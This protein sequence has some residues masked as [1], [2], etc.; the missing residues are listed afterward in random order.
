ML[1]CPQGSFSSVGLVRWHCAGSH[2]HAKYV[3]EALYFCC[4]PPIPTGFRDLAAAVLAQADAGADVEVLAAALPASAAAMRTQATG[5]DLPLEPAGEQADVAP[6]PAD[7]APGRQPWEKVVPSKLPRD[8]EQLGIG[9]PAPAALP[10]L[11]DSLPSISEDALGA[12]STLLAAG[13]PIARGGSVS[14]A[15]LGWDR[16]GPPGSGDKGLP[17]LPSSWSS[18]ASEASSAT[19]VRAPSAEA[20][21]W[22]G[23]A[24]ERSASAS[25]ASLIKPAPEPLDGAAASAGGSVARGAGKPPVPR[26]SSFASGASGDG[27][28][29]GG[30]LPGP[31]LS[32]SGSNATGSAASAAG[33]PSGSL[34]GGSN[35]G[36]GASALPRAI[37]AVLATINPHR[38]AD[39]EAAGKEDRVADPGCSSADR[40]PDRAP[41]TNLDGTTDSREPADAGMGGTVSGDDDCGAAAV[42]RAGLGPS[43]PSEALGR[44]ELPLTELEAR[45]ELA[46]RL[47]G[48]TSPQ[49]CCSR[50]RGFRSCKSWH[51]CTADRGQRLWPSQLPCVM[52]SHLCILCKRDVPLVVRVR[53]ELWQIMSKAALHLKLNLPI[54][55]A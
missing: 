31:L 30:R 36:S 21:A 26:L 28:S 5:V 18:R 49:V 34:A 55:E 14:A 54:H 37:D 22:P 9:R 53:Y 10:A 33:N 43:P 19:A 25:G 3:L 41:P 23:A 8:S 44:Q 13:E 47:H 42:V 7:V 15:A 51:K 29:S 17:R 16:G 45:M 39:E 11:H 48:P 4:W 40:L 38:T 35:A 24:S 50:S 46:Q 2:S 1:Y 20:A 12:S 52:H 27:R 6:A 32:Q